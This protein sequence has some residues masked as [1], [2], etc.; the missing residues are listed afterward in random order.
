MR[1]VTRIGTVLALGVLLLAPGSTRAD[2]APGETIDKASW[3]KGKDLLPPSVLEWVKRG[4]YEIK[5]GKL[6]F[7]PNWEPEYLA[8]SESNAGKYELDAE[9]GVIDPKTKQ[10]PERIY[11]F[12][13]PKI[14]KDDAGAGVKVM[15]N[16]FHTDFKNTQVNFPFRIA[17]VGR[18][19]FER[20]IVGDS[21]TYYYDGRMGGPVPNPDATELR[22]MV[23][24]LGPASMEGITV[25]TWRFLDNRADQVWSYLPTIRRVRQLTAANRS[26]SFAGTDFVQD[27]RLL[28]FGKNQSFTWKLVGEQD[29]LVPA[30]NPKA[31][32]KLVAGERWEGGLEWLTTPEIQP[33]VW[34]YSQ[35]GWK[36]APWEPTKH[37][38][39]KRPVYLVE[40][41]PRDSYYNY[42]KQ[43]FYIDRVTFFPYYKVIYNRA[44][45]YWKTIHSDLAPAW[46]EDGSHRFGILSLQVV[47]D[48]K[49]DHSCVG[50]VG[51]AQN[52]FRFNTPSVQPEM[53]TVGKLLRKG[54]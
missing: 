38:W 48:D 20:E 32:I 24:V 53:F 31:P 50:E 12:P 4:D 44:G 5:V 54:K 47:K 35:S 11:G 2:V 3:E 19:G 22:E 7:D 29:V 43:V 13:F 17:W 36:A 10:R 15:W 51:S 14:S 25:M 1:P 33:P 6:E 9:G 37:V 28:W 49:T 18:S 34:G 26:D 40:G 45:E 52:V 8:A 27:D 39:V 16:K 42:G 23:R 46:N 21:W 30:A 41:N